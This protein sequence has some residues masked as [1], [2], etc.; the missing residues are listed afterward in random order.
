M[1]RSLSPLKKEKKDSRKDRKKD[2]KEGRKLKT[3]AELL[4]CA[5]KRTRE[6]ISLEIRMKTQNK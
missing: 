4:C 3:V 2:R 5:E 1:R 6:G